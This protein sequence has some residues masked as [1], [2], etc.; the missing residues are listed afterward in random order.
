MSYIHT[1][2]PAEIV[3]Y[4]WNIYNNKYKPDSN[5]FINIGFNPSTHHS[6]ILDLLVKSKYIMEMYGF[7]FRCKDSDLIDNNKENESDEYDWLIEFHHYKINEN[8]KP[9]FGRHCDD[10]AGLSA[11]VNTIIFYLNK[12]KTIQGGNLFMDSNGIDKKMEI[13]SGDMIIM[14]GDIEHE[15][16]PM[17]GH[18]NRMSIVVQLQRD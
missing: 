2:I 13:K 18:G 9:D 12:D 6:D 7:T 15:I 4:L 11:N 5:T 3:P 1:Q 16:E 14:R 17:D 10:N 8:F